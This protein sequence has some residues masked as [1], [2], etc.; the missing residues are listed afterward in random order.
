[1]PASRHNL[2]WL[3]ME[4]SGLYPE[5]DVP[6]EIATI[7]T[8]NDLNIMAEG[9]NLVIRQPDAVL[10]R[11]DDWNTEQHGRSG[12]T[13]SVRDSRISCAEAERQT[14]EFLERWTLPGTSPLCGNSIGQDRRFI[15]KYMPL[16]DKHL[17]YRVIDISS[18]KELSRRWFELDPPPKAE[19]HRALD[20]I[21][22]SIEELLF[23]RQTIFRSHPSSGE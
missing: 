9:P 19:G 12:L 13:K 7:I 4:M 21:R 15:R 3:D 8:D 16:L 11:M 1:M 20:D 5:T 10:D 22:E 14:L 17:H 18:L 23:Y 2:I 6:L